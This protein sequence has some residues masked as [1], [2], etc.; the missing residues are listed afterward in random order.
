MS[1]SNEETDVELVVASNSF[2]RFINPL[3]QPAGIVNIIVG[4][5]GGHSSFGT[6]STST[7]TVPHSSFNSSITG[8]TVSYNSAVVIVRYRYTKLVVSTVQSTGFLNYTNADGWLLSQVSG[9]T[10]SPF[11]NIMTSSGTGMFQVVTNAGTQLNNP[12]LEKLFIAT[13][14]NSVPQIANNTMVNNLEVNGSTS[15]NGTLNILE[16]NGTVF[17]ANNGSIIVDHE[18]NGGAS[19]IIFESRSNRGSN[20][21]YIQFQDASSVGAGG[22]SSRLII[23]T[24]NDADEHSILVPSGNVGIGNANPSQKLT[25][26]GNMNTSGNI[27]SSSLNVFDMQAVFLNL[28]SSLSVGTINVA[29]LNV[30]GSLYSNSMLFMSSIMWHQG[31]GREV[32]YF[33]TDGRHFYRG[34]TATTIPHTWRRGD[35]TNILS[36]T[37]DGNV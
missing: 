7:E 5:A 29:N 12:T 37:N 28:S 18:N 1:S 16:Q 26:A 10:S 8:Q 2:A 19:S 30:G 33:G 13:V 3:I 20:F 9:G 32:F 21:G 22:K 36:V 11:T 27:R 24:Q 35:V 25:V 17:G 34:G 31:A 6:I 14:G 23:G 4:T 15:L